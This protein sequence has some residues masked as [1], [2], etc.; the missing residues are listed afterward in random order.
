MYK[1]YINNTVINKCIRPHPLNWCGPAT[2][3]EILNILLD[4][5]YNV[6]DI[7]D[8]M[9]W[10]ESMIT[11]GNLGTKSIIQAVVKISNSKIEWEILKLKYDDKSWELLKKYLCNDN[12]VVYFHEPGHHVTLCGYISELCGYGTLYKAE[13]N[14][15][16]M[17]AGMLIPVSFKTICSNISTYKNSDIVVF[18]R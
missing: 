6:T 11:S 15:K 1:R 14:I 16:N 5:D 18:Y 2:I 9:N 17:E 13:H 4:T 12:V 10:S 8:R 3:A 7:A